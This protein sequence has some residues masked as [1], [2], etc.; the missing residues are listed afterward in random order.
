MLQRS[1]N[2]S[3]DLVL[4]SHTMMELSS[5][6]ER[7]ENVD[8]LWSKLVYFGHCRI[9]NVP[10]STDIYCSGWS[11]VAVWC[12]S[13]WGRMLDFRSFLKPEITL[14]RL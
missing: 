2:V 5:A 3:Y 4:S 9:G 11:L 7:L 14:L 13:K 10:K 6:E 1:S 8:L 12:S